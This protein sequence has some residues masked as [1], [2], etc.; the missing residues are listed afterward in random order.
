MHARLVFSLNPE[1]VLHAV[2]LIAVLG[3]L[4]GALFLI[5]VGRLTRR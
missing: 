2:L 3:M 4:F 1:F 5:G